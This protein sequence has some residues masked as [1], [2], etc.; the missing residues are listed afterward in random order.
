MLNNSLSDDLAGKSLRSKPL[1]IEN[2]LIV[3]EDEESILVESVENDINDNNSAEFHKVYE[4]SRR[5]KKIAA[6]IK[7]STFLP[8][9][10]GGFC[11]NEKKIKFEIWMKKQIKKLN[12]L[13][14]D[15][16]F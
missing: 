14:E 11:K 2:G 4:R 13:D 3:D 8:S 7:N 10:A 12:K 6:L 15:E 1:T 16:I 5:T 9:S